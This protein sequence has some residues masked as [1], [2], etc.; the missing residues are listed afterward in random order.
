MSTAEPF[1]TTRHTPQALRLA[2]GSTDLPELR[3]TLHTVRETV[4]ED[5]YR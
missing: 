2:L 1:A 4:L 3:A 5:A